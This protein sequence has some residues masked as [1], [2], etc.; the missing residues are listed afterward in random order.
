MNDIG[1]LCTHC[2]RDTSRAAGN[3]LFVNRVPSDTGEV[4]GYMCVDCQMIEC[5]FCDELPLD[6]IRAADGVQIICWNCQESG[7]TGE[8]E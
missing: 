8:E 5:D 2:G 1:N 6:Y 3:G 7:I 4:V